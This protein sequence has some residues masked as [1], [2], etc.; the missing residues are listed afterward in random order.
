M[1]QF[2][3]ASLYF[4]E[5]LE[6]LTRMPDTPSRKGLEIGEVKR[7]ARAGFYYPVVNTIMSVDG[8]NIM[9]GVHITSAYGSESES[10]SFQ[11]KQGTS[12]SRGGRRSSSCELSNPTKSI[13]EVSVDQEERII[14]L[15]TTRTRGRRGSTPSV[16]SSPGA[17]IRFQRYR[18]ESSS[19][20][21]SLPGPFFCAHAVTRQTELDEG[22]T[23]NFSWKVHMPSVTG[24]VPPFFSTSRSEIRIRDQ[25]NLSR[26]SQQ[27]DR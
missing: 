9:S 15:R 20:R 1:G 21:P 3:D 10:S 19:L 17:S 18:A 14:S 26:H 7:I 2:I 11:K 25:A 22:R 8:V 16:F 27:R 13:H 24:F 12:P 4:N 23:T 5:S 6:V